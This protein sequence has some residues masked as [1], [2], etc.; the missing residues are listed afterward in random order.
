MWHNYGQFMTPL[1]R[2]CPALYN[3]WFTIS[4]NL[5]IFTYRNSHLSI[6]TYPIDSTISPCWSMIPSLWLFLSFSHSVLYISP[7][8]DSVHL[9]S[10]MGLYDCLIHYYRFSHSELYPCFRLCYLQ[11]YQISLSRLTGQVPTATYDRRTSSSFLT[12][13]YNDIYMSLDLSVSDITVLWW[14]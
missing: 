1:H 8:D 3:M 4:N 13:D 11:A 14:I 6:T 7:P 10:S 2:A 12:W 9:C 5:H